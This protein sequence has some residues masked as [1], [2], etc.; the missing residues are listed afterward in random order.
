M[1]SWFSKGKQQSAP[2]HAMPQSTAS[3]LESFAVSDSFLSLHLEALRLPKEYSRGVYARVANVDTTRP[4]ASMERLTSCNPLWSTPV[5]LPSQTLAFTI[6]LFSSRTLGEAV[7]VAT[8]LVDVRKLEARIVVPLNLPG[9]PSIVVTT[10]LLTCEEVMSK[11]LLLALSTSSL[12][13]RSTTSPRKVACVVFKNVAARWVPIH[14]SELVACRSRSGT[15]HFEEAA[16]PAG[17]NS[18]RVLRVALYTVDKQGRYSL[19]GYHEASILELTMS[20][21]S[22][23]KP[24]QSCYRDGAPGLV[25]AR[26]DNKS[27]ER[28]VALA[29]EL[30]SN[31]TFA[32]SFP[33]EADLR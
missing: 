8:V 27:G 24:L 2:E 7:L 13:R 20:D 19:F 1:V 22:K 25:W 10:E 6:E 14:H 4:S 21:V 33:M 32:S 11:P 30:Y 16:V 12:R 3:S 26:G 17:G 31:K 5:L 23:P 29:F 18:T 28:R 9:R 15:V